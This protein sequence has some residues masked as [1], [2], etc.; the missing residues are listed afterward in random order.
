MLLRI[1]D[2]PGG[3][4]EFCIMG[5]LTEKDDVA[6]KKACEYMQVGFIHPES[7]V[8]GVVGRDDSFA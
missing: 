2:Y 4:A 5:C 1:S 6:L 7:R 8:G 3:D